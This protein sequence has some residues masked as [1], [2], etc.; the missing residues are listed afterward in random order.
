MAAVGV[1]IRSSLQFI[2][3]D[4]FVFVQGLRAHARLASVPHLRGSSVPR[5]YVLGYLVSPLARLFR[6]LWQN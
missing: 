3:R 4:V 2:W 6:Q 1:A 5:T